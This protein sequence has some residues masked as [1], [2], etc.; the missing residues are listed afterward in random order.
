MP[1]DDG[2]DEY[3]TELWAGVSFVLTVLLLYGYAI[4]RFDLTRIGRYGLDGERLEPGAEIPENHRIRSLVVVDGVEYLSTRE[5]D[6]E[7]E[8]IQGSH[9]EA[10]DGDGETLW[11]ASFE[12]DMYSGPV[13]ANDAVYLSV[14]ADLLALEAATG[15]TLW[16]LE[17]AGGDLAVVGD[18]IYT[19][20]LEFRAIRA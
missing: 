20:G 3:R 6:H 1:S 11:E 5:N 17:G 8:G 2:R 18:T 10:S 19:W 7:Q 14:D 15:E 16:E 9:L 4:D 13:V 12:R